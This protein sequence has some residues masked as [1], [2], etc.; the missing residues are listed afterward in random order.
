MLRAKYYPDGRLL[1]AK[2]K[3]GSS[4]TWRSVLAGLECFK[5][6]YIWRVGD[7]TQINIWDNNRI[8]FQ[9]ARGNNIIMTVE[10]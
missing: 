8:S 1:K 4:Y 9:M 5:Q 3:G 6:G 7:A 10:S 2:M